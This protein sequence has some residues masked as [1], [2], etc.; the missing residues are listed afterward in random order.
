MSG[1]KTRFGP[2]LSET[3]VTFRLWA[4]AVPE[5]SLVL[6]RKIAMPK[7]GEWLVTLPKVRF[8]GKSQVGHFALQTCAPVIA[9][10]CFTIAA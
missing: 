5:V 6:D 8:R 1:P 10:R 9:R 7:A 3:G 4:P 2:L